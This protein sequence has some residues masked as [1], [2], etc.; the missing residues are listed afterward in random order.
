M[1][2]ARADR[3]VKE[4]PVRK[5]EFYRRLKEL[6]A[7]CDSARERAHASA[8]TAEHDAD[9]KSWKD[10][11]DAMMD[12]GARL[13]ADAEYLG[14]VTHREEEKRAEVEKA[15]RDEEARKVAARVD[16]KYRRSKR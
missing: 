4:W 11:I 9:M 7:A 2:D 8:G 13:K 14:A 16:A 10:A 3:L 5:R 1:S 15:L 6:D 12:H